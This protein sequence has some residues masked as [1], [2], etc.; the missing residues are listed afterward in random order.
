MDAL[1]SQYNKVLIRRKRF[2]LTSHIF[3]FPRS[4]SYDFFLHLYLFSND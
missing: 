2:Y 1:I 3:C 4:A